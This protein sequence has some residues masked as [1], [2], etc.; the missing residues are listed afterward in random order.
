[1]EAFQLSDHVNQR[2]GMAGQSL[3]GLLGLSGGL[4]HG[5]TLGTFPGHPISQLWLPGSG[6]GIDANEF[7]MEIFPKLG[8]EVDLGLVVKQ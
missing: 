7:Q 5:L 8:Q 3:P 4:G 6:F 2:N 1:M